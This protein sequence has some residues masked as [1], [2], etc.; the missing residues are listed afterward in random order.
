MPSFRRK[1]LTFS[2]R[3]A[4]IKD[5]FGPGRPCSGPEPLFYKK[6]KKRREKQSYG[7]EKTGALSIPAGLPAGKR[8]LRRGHRQRVEI[9]LCGGGQRRR[10]LCAVLSAVFNRHGRAGADHG[11]GGG[12]GQPEKRRAGV[13]GPG[14]RRQQMAHSRLVLHRGLLPAIS[15]S[16]PQAPL[17][18][19]QGTPWTRF[20]STCW[21]TPGR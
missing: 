7:F 21:Q 9:P 18:I 20:S 12:P 2:L 13:Q 5:T 1:G 10:R 4:M 15:S 11:A 14:A 3:S 6:N 16:S 19:W 17:P 8:R